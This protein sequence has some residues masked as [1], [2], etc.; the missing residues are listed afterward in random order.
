M[1]EHKQIEDA[2]KETQEKF[3]N[4]F[5]ECPLVLTL[6]SAKDYRYVEVNDTFERVTGWKRNEVIGR[7]AF[8]IG[9]W[10]EPNRR[11]DLLRQLLSV[12]TVR[13]LEFRARTKRGGIW[14]GS[15]SA[16]LIEI[17]GERHVLALVADITDLK[18]AEAL[19]HESEENASAW[20]Q[21]QFR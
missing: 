5:R 9:L 8:D 10:V 7:T 21:T 12:G 15:L 14:I 20:W 17:N 3:L 16:A 4:L 11:I 1:T 6:S 19:L 18:R 13:N 2:L